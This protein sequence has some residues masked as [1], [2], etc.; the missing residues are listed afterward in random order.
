MNNTLLPA[1]CYLVV[2]KTILTEYDKKILIALYEPILGAM[3]VSLYLTLW[4][5]LQ[6]AELFSR[7]LTHH[8]LMS[9]LRCDLKTIKKSRE[10]LEA[11]GLLKTF[12]KK[13][14]VNEYIYELF[15]PLLPSEFFNHPILNVVLYNN[16]GEVEYDRLKT[17][18]QKPKV[19]TKDYQE[20]TK[21]LDDVYDSSKFVVTNEVLE[22]TT[23]SISVSDRID[24]DLLVSSMPNGLL[25]ERALNKR[26]KELINLLS[27]IYNIDTLKMVE[28]IRTVINDYGMIDKTNLRITCRKYY[29]FNNNALPTLVYRQQPEYLKSPEGDNSMRGKI[30]AM[31]ENT[32]PYDF[33]KSKNKGINPT[34]KELKLLESLLIDMEM[35]P[36][37]VNVL[38]DYVLRKNNNKLTNAYVETIAAQ[39]SRAGLKNAKDAM[40]FAEKEHKKMLKKSTSVVKKKIEKEPV[41]FNKNIDKEQIS[42]DEQKE[43]QDLLKEFK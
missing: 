20:I 33:L 28:I 4:N 19:D 41:W 42:E 14:N 35:P 2:N 34:S 26:I 12:V 6:L 11:L 24:F 17:F 31:F 25:N 36:A 5:D 1:D 32:S 23:S 37:V 21:M 30:I 13:G 39:W 43:L 3:P 7:N 15:S 27:F 16:V 9:I 40:A 8:H 10:A 29:S 38:I 22:R 18:Y